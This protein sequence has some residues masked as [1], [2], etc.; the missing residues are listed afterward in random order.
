[1]LLVPILWN[2][3]R[4][5]LSGGRHEIPLDIPLVV[6]SHEHLEAGP[7]LESEGAYPTYMPRPRLSQLS[8]FSHGSARVRSFL[9]LSF[10]FPSSVSPAFPRR[11]PLLRLKACSPP[12]EQHTNALYTISLNHLPLYQLSQRDIY[13]HSPMHSNFPVFSFS[14]RLSVPT[15]IRCGSV[16][17]IHMIGLRRFSF[18]TCYPFLCIVLVTAS[19]AFHMYATPTH[20]QNTTIF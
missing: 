9:S 13:G 12:R 16:L 20:N 19:I 11:V 5:T 15:A 4:N 1:M 3:P 6:P 10:S 17:R 2:R 7:T 8:P 14:P 18:V